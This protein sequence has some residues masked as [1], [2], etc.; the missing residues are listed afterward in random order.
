MW[1]MALWACSPP[2]ISKDPPPGDDTVPTPTTTPW[3]VPTGTTPPAFDEAAL[4]DGLR[5]VVQ[6]VLTL[7][8]APAFA[9]YDEV[10]QYGS[11]G[12]PGS[13]GGYTSTYGAAES[14]Y[15]QCQAPS[16]AVFSG[17]VSDYADFGYDPATGEGYRGLYAEASVIDPDGTRWSGAGYWARNQYTGGGAFQIEVELD[18]VVDYAGPAADGTWVAEQLVP[19]EID[20]ARY[21]PTD[22][23]WQVVE[24]TGSLA[25]LDPG[26]E[27]LGVDTIELVDVSLDSRDGCPEPRGRI[28]L[29]TA[30]PDWFDLDFDGDPAGGPDAC[31]GC[32]EARWRG[33]ALGEVC[34]D[35]SPWAGGAR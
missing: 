23:R 16:G 7:D 11:G 4:T 30:A 24:A 3:T 5:T 1:V 29:R 33:V 6:R 35:F 15:S 22:G 31:D 17:Y 2:E 25:G 21:G 26:P 13:Y 12:C 27:G 8:A 19:G 18:G 28:S 32:A 20:I 10:M 34:A 14:W 9:T